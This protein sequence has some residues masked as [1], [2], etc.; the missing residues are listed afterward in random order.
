M[1]DGDSVHSSLP[2][3]YRKSYQWICEGKASNDEC[4][5]ILVAA[6]KQDIKNKG[7]LP[8]MIANR[9]S[10]SLAQAINDAGKNGSVDWAALNIKFDKLVQRFN[11]PSDLK[12][13]TL[14]AGKSIIHDLR[15]GKELDI[16]N[17][18]KAILERYMN[19]VY[20]S[21]F[22]ECIPLTSEHPAGISEA[23]LSRRIEN[24]QPHIDAAKSVWADKATREKSVENLRMPRH[25][26]IEIDLG[27]DLLCA[28]K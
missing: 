15:Y 1:A 10:E 23:I 19:Q 22:K 28:V 2:P 12:E 20:E 6:L 3:L 9:M 4:S 16:S 8:V 5:R 25:Q 18:S 27:E 13:L 17:V 11:G 21:G 26:F 14:Y 7:N 24:M